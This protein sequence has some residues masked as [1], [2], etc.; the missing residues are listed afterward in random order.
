MKI[1]FCVLGNELKTS[2]ET[3]L[4]QYDSDDTII[5]LYTN[6]I[7]ERISIGMV[8]ELLNQIEIGHEAENRWFM[9]DMPDYIATAEALYGGLFGKF[10][11]FPEMGASYS[12]GNLLSEETDKNKVLI[13]SYQVEMMAEQEDFEQMNRLVITSNDFTLYNRYYYWRQV[14][15]ICLRKKNLHDP[16]Q[17][18]ELYRLIYQS[19]Y[20]A[21]QD[22]MK[23]IPKEE[24]LENLIYIF[25][26]Q[27][28]GQQHPPTRSALERISVLYKQ[29]H[30]AVK[31]INTREPMTA[32]GKFPMF[33]A[34]CASIN[35]AI[36]GSHIF[37]YDDMIFTLEQSEK[38]MPE[39][40]EVRKIL[41][42]VRED[43]P[44]MILVIGNG[45]IVADMVSKI[46]PV[47]NI[48][49]VF[50][51]VWMHEGQYT[52]VGKHLSTEERTSLFGSTVLP[53]NIIES[54]FSFEMKEQRN[55][56]TR[57][58]LQLP[59]NRFLMLVVGTRLHDEVDD[60][61]ITAMY[62]MFSNGAFLVFVGVF[63]CYERYCTK[64]PLLQENSTFLGYQDDI[65]AVDELMDLYVNP[66]RSGGGYSIIEAFS[67]DVP[68]VTLQNGDVAAAAG[69]AFC[70][71][72]Y[73][74]MQRTIERYMT[75]REFYCSQVEKAKKR[76]EEATDATAALRYILQEA[77]KRSLF[78]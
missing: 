33:S 70:V 31:V 15:R 13:L 55:H 16:K 34:T 49:V 41:L 77:Q 11:N 42:K 40:G 71:E 50:S 76:V 67:K 48:P 8:L 72:S 22:L 10:I 37:Q 6:A 32:L 17:M 24:R 65:L 12:S 27:F 19:Y 4:M 43:K 3:A 78:F 73:A 45:S 69:D 20:E 21:C 9:S 68:G 57:E 63:D 38:D 29:L 14:A 18:Q 47:I 30:K 39:I 35:D 64:Y 58:D 2:N 56:Y 66:R 26:L 46:V 7:V 52:A 25:T 5:H 51:S 36:T 74:Q 61:F 60:D 62:P 44:Y 59:K 54:T 53:A 1:I 23:P 75:D 28:I